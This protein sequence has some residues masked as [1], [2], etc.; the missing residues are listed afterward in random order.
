[1]EE[2][3]ALML[4]SLVSS[5]GDALLVLDSV[6]SSFGYEKEEERCPPWC[7]AAS[8]S[9][10]LAQ[11][12]AAAEGGCSHLLWQRGCYVRSSCII[13][14]WEASLSASFFLAGVELFCMPLKLVA[15]LPLTVRSG[16]N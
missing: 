12:V 10:R 4:V 13:S 9:S 3:T 5:K 1:M 8:R 11:M 16:P 2:A 15:K 6:P 7:A 14:L